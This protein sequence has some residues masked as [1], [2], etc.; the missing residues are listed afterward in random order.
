MIEETAL[1]KAL[2]EATTD[3]FSMMLGLEVVC[4]ESYTETNVRGQSDGI[5]AVIGLAGEWI[6]TAS[7]GC[8]AAMG[9]RMSSHM[10]GAEFSEI[11]EEVLDAISEIAN[12]IVGSFKTIAEGYLGPLGL[13]IPTVIHGLSFSVRSPGK[14]QWIVVPFSCGDDT[15][16]VKVC[17]TP[18]R[19]RPRAANSSDLRM[20][21]QSRV[22]LPVPAR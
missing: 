17:L 3:V 2:S 22:S 20:P 8:T 14:Q 4:G 12:M 5:I 18:N 19:S 10:L 1:V 21:P 13:S 7:M 11:D 9:C 6:G 15:L 16:N